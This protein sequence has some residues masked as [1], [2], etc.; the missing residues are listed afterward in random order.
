MKKIT[1]IFVLL[2]FLLLPL[3]TGC[4]H[5]SKNTSSRPILHPMDKDH[6]YPKI[7]PEKKPKK[8]Q[9]KHHKPKKIKKN[10][11]KDRYAVCY[12]GETKMVKEKNVDK[13]VRKGAYFGKCR[14]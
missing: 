8:K 2:S 14:R 4:I 5:H 12:K 9:V 7:I 6:R 1:W 13:F 11:K 3:L 10:K